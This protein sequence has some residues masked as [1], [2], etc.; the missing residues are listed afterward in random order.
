MKARDVTSAVVSVS[1][2]TPTS[3]IA[4]ILRDNAISAMPVVVD[5]AGVAN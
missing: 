1:P 3:V 5:G 2:E 4:E